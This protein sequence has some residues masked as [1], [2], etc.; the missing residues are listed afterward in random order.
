M[1]TPEAG[2]FGAVLSSDDP[3]FGG[4]GRINSATE[5]FTHPEGTPGALHAP[6]AH[7]GSVSACSTAQSKALSIHVCCAVLAG[8][9]E[10]NFNDRAFSMLVLAPSR[11][12]AVYAKIPEAGAAASLQKPATG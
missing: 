6:G 12:V 3:E 8:V 1:G 11:T 2:K 7:A 4:Q 10:T 5:H 9:R